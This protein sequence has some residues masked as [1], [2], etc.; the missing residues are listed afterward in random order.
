MK[1]G[2]VNDLGL[3]NCG[4]CKD[5]KELPSLHPKDKKKPRKERRRVCGK[6]YA[7]L[8]RANEPFF[9]AKKSISS[10]KSMAK[11][12]DYDIRDVKELHKWQAF[13]CPY[14]QEPIH[15]KFTLEHI[16]PRERGG[17]NILANMLLICNTCNSSKQNF[18]LVYWLDSKGYKVKPKILLKI[19]GA[20]HDHGYRFEAT[21]GH[22]EGNRN[23]AICA[24]SASSP[25]K[26]C[27][28][29]DSSAA[30]G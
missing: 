22:C 2:V 27:I 20:Y 6:C 13:K 12:G 7:A 8:Q 17:R 23:K 9:F 3:G 4:E 14:C 24:S 26:E 21:C 11:E 28:N 25:S 30:S 5:W 18:E 29:S 10:H 1:L 15:Y 16:V 19:K